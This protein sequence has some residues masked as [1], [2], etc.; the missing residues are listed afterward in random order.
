MA[1]RRMHGLLFRH[2]KMLGDQLY[3]SLAIQIGLDPD[4]LVRQMSDN[5]VHRRVQA[6]IASGHSLGVTGT[7]TMFLDGRLVPPLC[8]TP[9]FW[10]AVARAE[11]P[12]GC[13]RGIASIKAYGRVP[14]PV[15]RPLTL[16]PR[17]NGSKPL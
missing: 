2:R 6:D 16:P 8:Q 7:P 3:P 13:G 15:S 1:F 10:Q 9:K 5:R 14:M 4:L 17:G 11:S 12:S